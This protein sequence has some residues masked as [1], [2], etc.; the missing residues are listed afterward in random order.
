[1]SSNSNPRGAMPEGDR[2]K[3]EVSTWDVLK[4]MGEDIIHAVTP[5]VEKETRRKQKSPKAIRKQS[6]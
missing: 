2:S 4:L 1:M 6:K 5:G 3:Y